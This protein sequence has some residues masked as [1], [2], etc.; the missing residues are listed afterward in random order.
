MRFYLV[1]TR[2]T[3]A[4]HEIDYDR[5][6]IRELAARGHEVSL[7]LPAGVEPKLNYHCP[8]VRLSAKIT[9]RGPK[10]LKSMRGEWARQ[11]IYRELAYLMATG[12]AE[13]VVFPTA[14]YRFLRAARLSPL[15]YT[16]KPVIF[17]IHGLSPAEKPK[18]LTHLKALAANPNIKAALH[19]LDPEAWRNFHPNLRPV[20]PPLYSPAQDPAA[21]GPAW[22]PGQPITL[23]FFG[24]YRREKNL[25]ALLEAFSRAKFSQPVKMVIQ[26]SFPTPGDRRDFERIM[27][28]H[29]RRADERLLFIPRPLIGR[30]WQEA[31]S[32]AQVLL[33]TY[34]TRRYLW[35]CSAVLFNALGYGTPALAS[36]YINPEVF[37]RFK[38]GRTFDPD[39]PGDLTRVLEEMVNNYER[40]RD[41]YAAGLAAA[42]EA[43]APWRLAQAL[44][45]LALSPR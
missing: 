3:P 23:G 5:L 44:E 39:V 24:Q 1:E 45:D 7:V 19:T 8:V 34:E 28:E 35:Y 37:Q 43:Y 17:I 33:I 38:I 41:G 40:D 32:K 10:L 18:M 42:A 4:G 15:K 12:A 31:L 29:S 25:R 16:A 11:K 13:A 26:G 27:A 22:S 6:L 9:G 2:S 14:T 21:A 36:R 30:E 20:P